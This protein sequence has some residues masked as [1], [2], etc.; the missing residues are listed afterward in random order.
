MVSERHPDVHFVIAGNDKC[1][2]GNDPIYLKGESFKDYVLRQTPVDLNRF[3]FLGWLSEEQLVSLFRLSR[4]HVYW[5]LPFTLSWSCFQAM[6]TGCLI[7]ASDSPPVREVIRHNETG[8]LVDPLNVEQMASEILDAL[9]H[10][11][12]YQGIREAARELMVSNYSFEVCLPKL[13]SY[14]LGK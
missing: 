11:E 5:T 3:H 7:I 13:A 2:Y 12:R 14:Y 1:Y 8:I 9:A 6:A 4:A 10:P